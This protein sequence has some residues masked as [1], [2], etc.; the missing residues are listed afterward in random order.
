MMTRGKLARATGCNIE[1]VRH[2]ERVG[3]LSTPSRTSSGYRVYNEEHLNQLNF[4]QHAKALGF[5]PEQ[6]RELLE[7]SDHKNKRTRADVKKLTE[8]HISNVAKKNRDLQ[9]IKKKLVDI[10]FY[11]DGSDGSADSCPILTSLFDPNDKYQ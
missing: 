4:I 10:S 11:C 2:Y 6:I 3:L 8:V 7:L 5:P 1:T 9:K